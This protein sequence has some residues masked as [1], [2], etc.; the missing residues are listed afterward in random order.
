MTDARIPALCEVVAGW[1]AKTPDRP[2][3]TIDVGDGQADEGARVRVS[4][5]EVAAIPLRR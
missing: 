3:L 2:I 1:A 4:I 5:V